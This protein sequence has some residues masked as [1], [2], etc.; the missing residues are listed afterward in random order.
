[1]DNQQRAQLALWIDEHRGVISKVAKQAGFTPQYVSAVIKGK[2]KN[3][4]ISRL[5]M[6]EGAPL[7]DE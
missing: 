5:L 1:V 2:R 4:E 3:E 7:L 6:L